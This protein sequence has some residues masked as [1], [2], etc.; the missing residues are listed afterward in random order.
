MKIKISMCLIG[1]FLLLIGVAH[2]YDLWYH[3]ASYPGAP[4]LLRTLVARSLQFDGFATSGLV[5]LWLLCLLVVASV[6]HV[7]NDK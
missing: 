2:I 5:L 3:V 4:G 1:S 6:A 7:A